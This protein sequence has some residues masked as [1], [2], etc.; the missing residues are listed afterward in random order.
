MQCGVWHGRDQ[1]SPGSVPSALHRPL[2]TRAG[3]ALWDGLNIVCLL[4]QLQVLSKQISM[5]PSLPG[6]ATAI[7]VEAII[8]RNLFS[9]PQNSSAWAGAEGHQERITSDYCR[10][11]S[12]PLSE[13]SSFLSPMLRSVTW[14]AVPKALHI[15]MRKSAWLLAQHSAHNQAMQPLLGLHLCPWPMPG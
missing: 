10:C 14:R 4:A 6:I 13:P 15:W 8:G 2:V 7:S 12:H 3:C 1:T 11:H 5:K 9:Q